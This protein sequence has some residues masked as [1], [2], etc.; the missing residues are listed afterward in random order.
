MSPD[1]PV[2]RFSP[3]FPP[4]FPFG[5]ARYLRRMERLSH[6]RVCGSMLDS[7]IQLTQNPI[8]R[9]SSHREVWQTSSIDPPIEGWTAYG[10]SVSYL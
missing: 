7:A 2:S 10:E 9:R 6:V 8:D 4:I 5:S 1:F 3:I